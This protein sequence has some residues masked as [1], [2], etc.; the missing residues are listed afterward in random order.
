[1]LIKIQKSR[2]GIHHN[3]PET[4][5]IGVIWKYF[6]K[7]DIHNSTSRLAKLI[8]WIAHCVMIREHR[9][10]YRYIFIYHGLLDD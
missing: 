5:H 4:N 1:M 8:G 9:E 7:L 10:T 3:I 6:H 2:I